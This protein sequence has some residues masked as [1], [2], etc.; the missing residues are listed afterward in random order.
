MH[1]IFLTQVLYHASLRRFLFLAFVIVY[2]YYMTVTFVNHT[3]NSCIANSIYVVNFEQCPVTTI[4]MTGR[5]DNEF[6]P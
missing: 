4:F 6:V 2:M 5:I 1:V 3:M